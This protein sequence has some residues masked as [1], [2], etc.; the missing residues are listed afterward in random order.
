MRTEGGGENWPVEGAW[1]FA[2]GPGSLP[3]LCEVMC[4]LF[5]VQCEK[6]SPS[7]PLFPSAF[8]EKDHKA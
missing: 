5:P 2:G 4:E 7:L 3:S 8:L 1:P 6:G